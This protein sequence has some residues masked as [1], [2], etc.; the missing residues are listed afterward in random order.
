MLYCLVLCG[1]THRERRHMSDTELEALERQYQA[2][3]DRVGELGFV[4]PGSVIE[5]H[6][7]W[8]TSSCHCQAEPP[9]RHGPY[10]QY[11]R[12][13]GGKTFTRRLNAE[14]AD[15]Y[16]EWI[17][18]RRHLDE[19]LAQM[20]QISRRT[21]ELITNQLPPARRTRPAKP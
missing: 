6:T 10:F 8:A 7:V 20:D 21:A 9:V 14:Q 1:A 12:K 16:R 15:L 11:T 19:I 2:L 18:N 3:Q 5:R 17:A 13:L 4:A